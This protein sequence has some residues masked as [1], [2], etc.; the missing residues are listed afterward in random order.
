MGVWHQVQRRS[1]I[2][3]EDAEDETESDVTIVGTFSKTFVG[4]VND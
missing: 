4:F 1:G 2:S 3:E